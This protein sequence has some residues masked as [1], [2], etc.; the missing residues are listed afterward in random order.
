MHASGSAF[1]LNHSAIA[2]SKQEPSALVELRLAEVIF[3]HSGDA[4]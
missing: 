4:G 1:P 3:E 2:P